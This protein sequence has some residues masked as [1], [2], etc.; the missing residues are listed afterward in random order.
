VSE[1]PIGPRVLVID[2]TCL[3][4]FALADRLDDFR[5][6]LIDWDCWTTRVVIEELRSG[7]VEYPALKDAC[8]LDWIQV[9]ELDSLDEFRAF[10]KWARLTGSGDRDAGEASVFAVAELRG[11]IALTDDRDAT[12]AAR[13]HK[14]RAHGTV[15]L[16]AGACRAGKLTETAAGSIIDS[17]RRSGARLPCSG[18][19][20]PQFARKHGLLG[21]R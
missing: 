6:L 14:L 1:A 21:S 20:F 9:A 5:E 10:A 19:E 15:W 2:T 12:A 7:S 18:A 16:L 17:L 13:T 3:S 11:G 8:S 4:H